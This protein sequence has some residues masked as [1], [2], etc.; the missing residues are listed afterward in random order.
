MSDNDDDD[1]YNSHCIA[2]DSD[3]CADKHHNGSWL[4]PGVKRR[5]VPVGDERN[6]LPIVEFGSLLWRQL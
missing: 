3:A 2:D 6:G 5:G 4:L 1:N